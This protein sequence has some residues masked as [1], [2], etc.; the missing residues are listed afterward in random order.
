MIYI[1]ISCYIV[2]SIKF[3]AIHFR[4]SSYL[5]VSIPF[6]QSPP[7]LPNRFFSIVLHPA[8]TKCIVFFINE[9]APPSSSPINIKY[10]F[11]ILIRKISRSFLLSCCWTI[12]KFNNFQI[13]LIR[14]CFQDFYPRRD[15]NPFNFII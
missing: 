3:H 14:K 2:F 8:S 5:I 1:Y 6:N 15:W 9:N 12:V 10:L 13:I 4:F 11:S 7:P